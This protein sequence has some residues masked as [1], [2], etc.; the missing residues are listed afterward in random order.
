VHLSAATIKS[1]QLK[2]LLIAVGEL[3]GSREQDIRPTE[4]TGLVD[5]AR[6][7]CTLVRGENI[8][9]DKEVL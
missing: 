5:L 3:N 4:L 9:E 7:R 2:S 1:E 8:A 6:N